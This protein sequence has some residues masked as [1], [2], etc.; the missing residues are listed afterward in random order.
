MF[1]C[2]Q[3]K[4]NIFLDKSTQ[5]MHTLWFKAV[6]KVFVFIMQTGSSLMHNKTKESMWLEFPILYLKSVFSIQ[7]F[8]F[9]YWN[10][11]WIECN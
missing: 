9:E 10:G 2:E 11:I 3:K 7:S 4:K 8:G 5:P 1:I 6:F